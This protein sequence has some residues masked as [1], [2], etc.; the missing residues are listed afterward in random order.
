MDNLFKRGEKYLS[1]S[2]IGDIYFQAKRAKDLW[3]G[4]LLRMVSP[5]V[6]SN[7]K[8]LLK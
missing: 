5:V 1:L 8:R 6:M 3:G 4:L 7:G 2:L